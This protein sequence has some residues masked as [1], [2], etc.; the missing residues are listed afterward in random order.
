MAFRLQPAS[1][2]YAM[3]QRLARLAAH[4]GVI[5][6]RGD[7]EDGSWDPLVLLTKL[8]G[9]GPAVGA[10]VRPN[11]AGA[12][13][14]SLPY[15]VT[16]L[17]ATGLESPDQLR[18][19]MGLIAMHGRGVDL[20]P[21]L[22]IRT[23]AGYRNLGSIVALSEFDAVAEVEVD[24][25]ALAA[26]RAQSLDDALDLA[27]DIGVVVRRVGKRVG[28]QGI[29]PANADLILRAVRPDTLHV[30]QL[31]VEPARVRDVPGTVHQVLKFQHRLDR[32]AAQQ[33]EGD[34]RGP[35]GLRVR[36]G[37]HSDLPAAL[38]ARRVFKFITGI[39]NPD[40]ANVRFLAEVYGAAGAD[41]IDV[42]ARPDI[43]AAAGQAIAAL[44]DRGAGSDTPQIMV[45][46]AL[47]HDPHLDT[48]GE[49]GE[50]RSF[51]AP[52]DTSALV[53][54]VEACLH[55]GADM[56]ELHASDSPDGALRE[57]VEAL[58]GV[59]AGR[60]LS[61]CLGAEGWRSPRDV[62]RQTELVLEIHGPDTMIQAEGVTLIKDGS[63]ASS[64]QGLALAQTV[65]A[66]TGAYCIVAGGANYWTRNLADTLGVPIHGIASGSYARQ[67]VAGCTEVS[68]AARIA[69]QFAAHA[70][71]DLRDAL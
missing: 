17:V 16:S 51:I 63:L 11:N 2:T 44:R 12:I 20:R 26:D 43:V 56:V 40:R 39:T 47:D 5:E 31:V 8:S 52:V 34:G 61:V 9:L 54:N 67:L 15:G 27:R 66:G 68:A 24:V 4:G 32:W 57:A 62:I 18:A 22:Q 45:S 23:M 3:S 1:A 46:L 42:A 65:L 55:A 19:F 33:G 69:R 25:A 35:R 71:G 50:H 37:R 29:T 6:W 7:P 10:A 70:K 13:R 59:L 41:I 48:A 21:G 64:V 14:R 58:S 60:Y 53:A 38:A 49:A 36:A 28:V 30:G